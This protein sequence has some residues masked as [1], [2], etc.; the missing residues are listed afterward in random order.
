[1][2]GF[3]MGESFQDDSWIQDFED[4][5]PQKVILKMLNWG[6]YISFSDLFSVYLRTIEHSILKL[7]IFSGHTVSLKIEISKVQDFW[8]F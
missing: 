7:W 3:H 2:N 8:N 1:M 5:F 4:D 6:D